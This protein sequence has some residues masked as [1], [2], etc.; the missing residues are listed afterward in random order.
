MTW[1]LISFK[2]LEVV[3]MDSKTLSVTQ[4]VKLL[5]ESID[6]SEQTN[7]ALSRCKDTE[8]M[9]DVLLGASSSLG[10]DLT[11]D[12]LMV[13]PPIRDWIWWK[14][15]EALVTLGSGTPRHQQ[16]VSGKTRWDAWSV[17]LFQWFG[18]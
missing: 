3:V 11:R 6:G 1:L 7:E 8:A 17:R 16:D 10:L 18:K 9:L 14:N 5:V 15:K 4:R 2:L 12:E 13:T